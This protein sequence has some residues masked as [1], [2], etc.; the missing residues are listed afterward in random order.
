MLSALCVGLVRRPCATHALLLY[1]RFVELRILFYS[2]GTR[3]V[4]PSADD[5][6]DY[7]G[8]LVRSRRTQVQLA[9]WWNT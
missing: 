9:G 1:L 5:D 6:D 2:L 4:Q 3:K 7:D 8:G